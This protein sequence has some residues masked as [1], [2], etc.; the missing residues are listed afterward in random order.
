MSILVRS[1]CVTRSDPEAFHHDTQV[2]ITIN[3]QPHWSKKW[4][5]SVPRVLC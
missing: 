5:V 2:D 3:G 4:S 1:E